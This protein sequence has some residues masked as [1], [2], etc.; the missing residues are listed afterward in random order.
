MSSSKQ[1]SYFRTLI[2][3]IFAFIISLMLLALAWF[4]RDLVTFVTIVEV[5]IFVIIGYCISNIVNYEKT[6]QAMRS[7]NNYVL[8]MDSCPD[9]YVKRF[10]PLTTKDFCSNEYRVV[11][12][13]S[14]TGEKVI[15]KILPQMKDVNMG[16]LVV[17]NPGNPTFP[18]KHSSEF[19]T[20]EGK[21]SKEPRP[22]DKFY[23]S[24]LDSFKTTKN[25]CELINPYSTIGDDS[26]LRELKQVPWTYAR[27]RC[28]G[29][30]VDYDT[31]KPEKPSLM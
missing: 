18:T 4:K 23:I 9:Y 29:L 6:L 19:M 12:K 3:T 31:D 14:P 8:K 25:K 22:I 2:F 17:P 20:E 11:D 10:D 21:V 24:A 26:R 16:G 28:N 15:M 13:S 30:Y 5:A 27:S 7:A 1:V